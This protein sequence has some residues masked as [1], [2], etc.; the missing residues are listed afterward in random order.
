[1]S[2]EVSVICLENVNFFEV[3][4]LHAGCLFS[5]AL[6][7]AAEAVVLL[8]EFFL[9]ALVRLALLVVSFGKLAGL[10]LEVVAGCFRLRDHLPML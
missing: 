6:D 1:V 9:A 3:G 4:F 2:D 7:L 5:L 8:D 10:K